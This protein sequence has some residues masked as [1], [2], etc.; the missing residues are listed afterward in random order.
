M[1][2]KHQSDTPIVWVDNIP[3][4][5][6]SQTEALLNQGIVPEELKKILEAQR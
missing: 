1:A 2:A 6:S 3:Y 5:I 4:N